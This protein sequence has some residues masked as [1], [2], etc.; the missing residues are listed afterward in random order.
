MKILAIIPA[1]YG[2]TRLPG[3]PL[4]VIGGKPMIQRVYEQ[5]SSYHAIEEVCVATDDSRIA[6]VVKGFGGKVFLTSEHHKTGTDRCIEVL[7]QYPKDSFDVVINVQGDEPFVRKDQLKSI[8]ELLENKNVQIASLK[9]RITDKTELFD[10]NS[11]KV[12]TD[13]N[14]RALLFSRHPIPYV[15]DEEQENWLSQFS[16]Y[17]HLGIYGFKASVLMG[18]KGLEQ[19]SLEKAESLEQLRWMENG[20]NIYLA[21]TAFQ[22]P[23]VDTEEDLITV[24]NFLKKHKEFL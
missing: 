12:A 21:E 19:G 6:N 15:R 17:K 20:L 4:K 13:I 8:L 2:S 22:S 9:K 16:F 5:V 24:E 7:E 23:S 3:K 11:V 14:N 1:R 18:I 10:P